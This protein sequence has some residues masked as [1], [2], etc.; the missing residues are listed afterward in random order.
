MNTPCARLVSPFIKLAV[1]IL[2]LSHGPCTPQDCLCAG[3]TEV[4]CP[5]RLCHAP[6]THCSG[7]LA[8]CRQVPDWSSGGVMGPSLQKPLQGSPH[9]DMTCGVPYWTRPSAPYDCSSNEWPACPLGWGVQVSSPVRVSR[10]NLDF[11]TI[12]LHL[13]L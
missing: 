12:R 5:W 6:S 2:S 13:T 7:R 3:P 4:S 10:F 8:T 9:L 1:F 11:S